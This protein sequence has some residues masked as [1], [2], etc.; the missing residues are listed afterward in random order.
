MNI[1]KTITG[2]FIAENLRQQNR[3]TE[4]AITFINDQLMLY[5]KKLKQSEIA[6]MEDKLDKLLVDSTNRHP[7]VIQLKKEI[8]ASKNELEKGDYELEASTPA[9]SGDE[10]VAL[11]DELKTLRAE[12][13]TSN[14]DVGRGGENRIK[15]ATNTNEK[16]YKMLLMERIE[17]VAAQ[18]AGVN[19]RLYD[20]LLQRLE[21]AK[22]TQRLEASKDGTRYIIL[23]PARLPL[24]PI[25]PNK[26]VVLF[27]GMF[28]GIG[29]GVAFV[30]TVELFDHSFLTVEEAKTFLKAPIL[31]TI[32]KIVTQSDVRAQ[33][34]HN[35]KVTGISLLTG[36]I[37]LAVIIFN[38]VLGNN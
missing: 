13:S 4:N 16:L 20:D 33:K 25:K 8:S 28:L 1:V 18:D 2:I 38:V 12:L 21:T 22:I 7:M 15:L 5:Q 17:K 14:L 30:I 3:E 9:V 24:K 32:S 23:D 6:A 34:I 37:L 19:K 31:G 26:L 10:R 11:K 29:V 35:I 36:T 27:V